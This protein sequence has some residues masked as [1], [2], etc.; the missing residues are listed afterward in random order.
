MLEEALEVGGAGEDGLL[1]HVRHEQVEAL[2][3]T[4]RGR[5]RLTSSGGTGTGRVTSSGGPPAGV[6][7]VRVR[8][9]VRLGVRARARARGTVRAGVGVR[10]RC[11]AHCHPPLQSAI[12][13]YRPA[14]A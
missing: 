3:L 8:A 9:R 1:A 4:S 14:R 13:A 12:L 10:V 7:R 2:L 11:G 5:G 6:V